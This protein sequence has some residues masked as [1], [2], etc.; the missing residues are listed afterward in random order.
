MAARA[1]GK[2]TELLFLDPVLHLAPRTS[3][4]QERM[5]RETLASLASLA[6]VYPQNRHFLDS[7]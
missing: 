2:K 1:V 7:H 6:R 5:I 3:G 4:R